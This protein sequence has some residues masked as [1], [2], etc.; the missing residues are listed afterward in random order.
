MRV[1]RDLRLTADALESGYFGNA[2]NMPYWEESETIKSLGAIPKG[3]RVYCNRYGL[4]HA[5]LAL[6]TRTPVRGQYP[7]LPA[8]LKKVNDLIR[9]IEEGTDE[10]YIVRLKFDG[11]PGY[12][13]DDL[14]LRLLQGVTVTADLSDGVIFRIRSGGR[15]S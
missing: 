8:S 10:V 9:S 7:T 14:D 5:V 15:E 12:D 11:G 4:L 3:A 2:Y 6:K 13:F 1:A